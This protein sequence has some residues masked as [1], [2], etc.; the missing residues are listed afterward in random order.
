MES[1][2]V[3]SDFVV[4]V[5]LYCGEGAR[6]TSSTNEIYERFRRLCNN[7]KYG[8][9]FEDSGWKDE[10]SC[11]MYDVVEDGI[12]RCVLSG[13]IHYTMNVEMFEVL[14]MVDPGAIFDLYTMEQNAVLMEMAQDFMSEE[15]GK[16]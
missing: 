11:R 13:V 16:E 6:F 3:P 2:K 1:Y 9:F 15:K 8:K 10:Y 5:I 12:G 4:A 14:G 7:E